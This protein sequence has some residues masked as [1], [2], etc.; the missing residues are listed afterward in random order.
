MRIATEYMEWGKSNPFDIGITCRKGIDVLESL[1]VQRLDV[2]EILDRVKEV[3]GKSQSN[4]SLMRI[5]PMACFFALL[6]EDPE[7]YREFIESNRYPKA[8]LNQFDPQQRGPKIGW[9]HLGESPVR[10]NPSQGQQ[11]IHLP[12]YL[13]LRLKNSK[14]EVTKI[15]VLTSKTR[16]QD[17]SCLKHGLGED[18]MDLWHELPL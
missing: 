10:A 14:R 15:M 8:R 16:G 18:S 9:L 2:K 5:A 1:K 3:T 11:Q 12:L 7:D 13:H 17:L 4:G 6:Q